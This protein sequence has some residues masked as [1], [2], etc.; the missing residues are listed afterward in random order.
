MSEQNEACGGLCGSPFLVV[1]ALAAALVV[2]LAGFAVAKLLGGKPSADLGEEA[3]LRRIQPMAQV[4]L[5]VAPAPVAAAPA[6][7][8]P[9]GKKTYDAACVACHG[10]GAAGAPKLGDKAAWAPRLKTGVEGLTANAIKGKGAMP[11]KGG[12]MSLSD[13]DMKAAVEYMTAAAK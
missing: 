5:S 2:P 7:A 1:V 10:S 9:D 4:T 13:A 11:P 12:N 8:A 3:T 6:G